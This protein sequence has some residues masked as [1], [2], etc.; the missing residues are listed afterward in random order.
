MR[1][2]F[3]SRRGN[4]TGIPPLLFVHL[5]KNGLNKKIN[6]VIYQG[7]RQRIVKNIETKLLNVLAK[8][9]HTAVHQEQRYFHMLII[10]VSGGS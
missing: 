9:V 4:V 1:Y 3:H 7:Q 10:L 6:S 2:F 8:F 5:P